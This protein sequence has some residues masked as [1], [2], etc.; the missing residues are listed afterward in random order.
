M[1]NYSTY[2]VLNVFE[3]ICKV[4]NWTV[5]KYGPQNEQ[6]HTDLLATKSVIGVH[7]NS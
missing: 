4:D 2:K 7:R 1:F 6:H 3:N 5:D